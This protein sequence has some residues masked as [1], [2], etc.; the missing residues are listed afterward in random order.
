MVLKVGQVVIVAVGVVATPLTA[1]HAFPIGHSLRPL[2]SLWWR[3]RPGSRRLVGRLLSPAGT[4]DDDKLLGAMDTDV[5]DE[6]LLTLRLV[7]AGL[8]VER[9]P[10]LR[11]LHNHHRWRPLRDRAMPACIHTHTHTDHEQTG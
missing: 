11:S 9:L 4:I 5:M 3:G 1:N 10:L 8:T 7:L 6:V 2:P